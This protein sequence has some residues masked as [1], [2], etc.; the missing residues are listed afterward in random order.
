MNLKTKLC[1]LKNYTLLLLGP[2]PSGH[3]CESCPCFT[4]RPL[5]FLQFTT[6]SSIFLLES[7]CSSA[8][9]HA[10]VAPA[11]G[12]PR[13]PVALRNPNLAPR[14]AL[15][16]LPRRPIPPPTVRVTLAGHP[17]PYHVGQT[18]PSSCHAIPMSFR[19]CPSFPLQF[20]LPRDV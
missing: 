16:H 18:L 7:P 2:S 12:R 6:G 15:S 17:S 1:I 9:L 20:L 3:W 10:R 14:V 11:A 19:R 5:Y 13:A 4:V 8:P